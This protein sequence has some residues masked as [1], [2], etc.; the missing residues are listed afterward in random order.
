MSAFEKG[1]NITTVMDEGNKMDFVTQYKC[2]GT[3]TDNHLN[4]NENFIRSY[5]RASTRLRLL[6]RL[7]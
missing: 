4:L 5:K 6:E 2:F 1:G 7:T 3:I